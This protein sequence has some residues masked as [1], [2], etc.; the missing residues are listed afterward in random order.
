MRTA[1]ALVKHIEN[2]LNAFGVQGVLMK[3]A[4]DPSGPR[5][6]ELT[7]GEFV[8]KSP[9]PAGLVNFYLLLGPGTPA[10]LRSLGVNRLPFFAGSGE[11]G[12]GSRW[13]VAGR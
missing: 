1:E 11:R 10:A 8:M 2:A 9:R 5:Q 13:P 6:L 12:A 4:S 7:F 3:I